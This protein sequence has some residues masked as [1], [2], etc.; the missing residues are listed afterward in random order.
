MNVRLQRQEAASSDSVSFTGAADSSAARDG[1][2]PA[3]SRP[4]TG[5]APPPIASAGVL[6]TRPRGRGGE[7]EVLAI[8]RRAGPAAVWE[9]PKGRLEPTD[10]SKLHCAFRELAEEAGVVLEPPAGG[11]Q[12]VG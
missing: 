4:A 5:P 8:R 7:P 6:L 1:G 12:Q 3:A 11:C 2:T 9:F 10:Q